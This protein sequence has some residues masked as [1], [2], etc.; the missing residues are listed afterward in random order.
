[1][2]LEK[3]ISNIKECLHDFRKGLKSAKI[4][5]S[6]AKAPGSDQYSVLTRQ[7]LIKSD[8]ITSSFYLISIFA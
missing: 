3:A 5:A 7:S 8:D 6:I 1:M 2:I 4:S